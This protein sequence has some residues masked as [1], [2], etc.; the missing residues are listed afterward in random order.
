MQIRD[1][2]SQETVLVESK[3]LQLKETQVTDKRV[4]A[5]G[6]HVVYHNSNC[7]LEGVVESRSAVG[8]ILV[9]SDSALLLS[10]VQM[11]WLLQLL[12]YQF[13]S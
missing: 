10:C 2:Q 8:V 13:H 4:T 5:T 11:G 1:A 7:R 6:A 12:S 9:R 3:R